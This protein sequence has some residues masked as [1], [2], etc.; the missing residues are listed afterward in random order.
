MI[1][2]EYTEVQEE[3]PKKEKKPKQKRESR[4]GKAFRSI[5]DGSILTRENVVRLLPFGLYIVGLTIIYIA[6]SYYTEKSI[7][8]I[9]KTKR[10]LR[11]LECEYTAV[12]S[13]VMTLTRQSEIA[14]LLLNRKS[15]VEELKSPPMKIFADSSDLKNTAVTK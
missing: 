11:E 4:L 6:N 15:E 1:K 14:R 10:E 12:K 3:Q 5:L 2:N 8:R 9:D 13:S 7:R